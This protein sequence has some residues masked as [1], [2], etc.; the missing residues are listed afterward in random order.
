MIGAKTTLGLLT[1]FWVVVMSAQYYFLYKKFESLN[2]CR[3]NLQRVAALKA[4]MDKTEAIIDSL[5][6]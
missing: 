4:Q 6:K 5:K 3:S 2:A 1:A